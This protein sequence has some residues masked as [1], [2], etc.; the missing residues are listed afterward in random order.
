MIMISTR[1][2]LAR[3]CA[4]SL[5]ATGRESPKPCADRMFGFTPC[6]TRYRT[7]SAARAVESSQFEGKRFRSSG[8]M[9]TLVEARHLACPQL[10]DAPLIA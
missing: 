8:P 4:A 6:A 1:R 2:F 3:P 5:D 10:L 9:G 7:T